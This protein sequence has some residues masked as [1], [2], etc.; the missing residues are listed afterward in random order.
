MKIFVINLKRSKKRRKSIERQLNRLS[1]KYELYEAVDGIAW[2]K[3]KMSH[4]IKKNLIDELP[5][6]HLAASLSH[7]FLYKQIVEN[8]IHQALI[9]E[10]DVVLSND[11]PEILKYLDKHPLNS[12]E[13]VLLHMQVLYGAKLLK[14][15]AIHLNVNKSIYYL[16]PPK[17]GIG[18]GA[19]YIITK[20][21]AENRLR[22]FPI[23]FKIDSWVPMMRKGI[24]EYLRCVY[25]YPVTPAFFP[26]DINY[27]NEESIKH[28]LKKLANNI[29]LL[30]HFLKSQRKETWISSQQDIEF[31]N[32][33]VLPASEL[34]K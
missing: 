11:L 20:E 10:D 31:S 4:Y 29:P 3:D 2:G 8:N 1:L 27:I 24:F 21:A 25:P 23:S 7:F 32:E 14:I 19:A 34:F 9:L 18:S 13:I 26:S 28:K 33:E 6:G 12:L 17:G 22:D 15:G 30:A 5:S 16:K